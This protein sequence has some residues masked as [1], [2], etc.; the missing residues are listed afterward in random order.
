MEYFGQ[1]NYWIFVIMLM[2]GLYTIMSRTNL[3]KK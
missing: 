3:I 1:F 2:I